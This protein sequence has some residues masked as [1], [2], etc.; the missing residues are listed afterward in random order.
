MISSAERVSRSAGRATR[1]LTARISA[2]PSKRGGE[3][4]IRGLS[5]GLVA[6]GGQFAGV[7]RQARVPFGDLP[8]VVFVGLWARISHYF[9]IRQ[10]CPIMQT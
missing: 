5:G 4:P 7:P 9:S 2:R 10:L 1:R 8:K 3:A 6:H